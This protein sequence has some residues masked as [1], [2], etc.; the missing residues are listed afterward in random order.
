MA[1]VAHIEQPRVRKSP[2]QFLGRPHGGEIVI[3]MDDKRRIRVRSDA[4][5]EARLTCETIVIVAQFAINHPIGALELVED[6]GKV[7]VSDSLVG[8][9]RP[10]GDPRHRSVNT[11]ANIPGRTFPTLT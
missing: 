5:I 9:L 11:P 6:F 1:S 2:R 10:D 8:K 4:G 3:A 7:L